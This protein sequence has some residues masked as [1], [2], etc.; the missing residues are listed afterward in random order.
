MELDLQYKIKNTKNY[1]NYLKENSYYIKKLNRNKNE[2]E[3]FSN[4]VKDKYG[5]R[6]T[7]K[8][9]KTIDN[10]DL[11]STLFIT[12]LFRLKKHLMTKVKCIFF[13]F[14]EQLCSFIKQYSI[15]VDFCHHFSYSVIVY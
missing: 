10:I 6:V 8:I 4:F 2:F 1:Y 13:L 15:F 12:N 5:L 11:I 3:N 7:D 14:K 9:S